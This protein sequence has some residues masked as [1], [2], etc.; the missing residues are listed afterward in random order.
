MQVL[1]CPTPDAWLKNALENFDEVLLDHAHCEKKAAAAAMAMVSAYPQ[2]SELVKKLTKLA[3]EELRHFAAVYDR[4]LAR[5][6]V[7]GR[8]SGDPYA[9]QLLALSRTSVEGRL[10]DR[11]LI[12]ALIEARSHERLLLLAGALGDPALAKFYGDLAKAEAGHFQL[13]VDLACVYEDAAAVK[14][15]LQVLAEKEAELVLR[16]P[17]IARIH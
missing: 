12:A 14:E 13:F 17:I 8:D 6:L 9:Q 16:L 10:T 3:L 15:R 4:L 11:L 1:L 7:L 5:E 2:H